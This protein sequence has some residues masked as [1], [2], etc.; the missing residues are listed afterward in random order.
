MIL[1]PKNWDSFQHYKNRRPPWIK[2]HHL[3]VDDADF[4]A[5][6]G[7]DAK[8]LV[9]IWLIASEDFGNLPPNP[10][11]AFR[12]RMSVKQLE[13]LLARLQAWIV[14]DASK[15]L[16]ISEQ[17]AT[18]EG[19]VEERQSAEPEVDAS[20]S[21]P[22]PPPLDWTRDTEPEI[23]DGLAKTQYGKFACDKAHIPAGYGL[24]VKVGDAIFFLAE[25]E[26]C[27][28]SEATR[29]M[30]PRLTQAQQQGAKIHLWLDDGGW[31]ANAGKDKYQSYLE[32]S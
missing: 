19:E 2:L 14:Y 15:P 13:Q 27:S 1:R 24:Q 22:S 31:K 16:A 30:V 29:R 28:H 7:D 5:L 6:K 3:L 23:P 25:L 4:H 11:L 20:A 8:Y 18:P 12:L 17:V 9:L 26:R 10:K 21:A 32:A